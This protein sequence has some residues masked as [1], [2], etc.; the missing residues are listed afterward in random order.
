M[1]ISITVTGSDATR[2]SAILEALARS[3]LPLAPGGPGAE[4]RIHDTGAGTEL[5][6]GNFTVRFSPAIAPDDLASAARLAV[7]L[8]RV[9]SGLHQLEVDEPVGLVASMVSHD[10]RNV[11]LPMQLSADA[12]LAHKDA[13]VVHFARILAD[14]SRRILSL[15]RRISMLQHGSPRR[16]DVNAIVRELVDTLAALV[17][18]N[19]QLSTRLESPLP[20]VWMDPSALERTL[21]NL[22]ANARDAS[23]P[24]GRIVISSS[25]RMT[26]DGSRWVVVA[27]EDHGAGMDATTLAH[28]L[29]HFFTTKAETGGTGLGLPSV[30]R[31][32]REAGG[33]VELDSAPGRGTRVDVW[34][35]AI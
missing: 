9:G 25:T 15:L 28:A 11:L 6:A 31:A 30:A 27:V 10:A 5:C 22:V 2:R 33:K 21:V 8:E 7:E 14:G 24:G 35:P 13:N 34:L 4:V 23:R 32:A 1:P 26:E 12:L 17:G 20:P 18:D 16:I 3:G 29:D 19:A